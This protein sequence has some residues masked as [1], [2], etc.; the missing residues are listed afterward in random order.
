MEALAG[1][2]ERLAT[3]ARATPGKRRS[4]HR[5]SYTLHD[6][7]GGPAAGPGEPHHPLPIRGSAQAARHDAPGGSSG[8]EEAWG[9]WP[10]QSA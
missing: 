3:S 6:S 2:E 8:T 1:C 10:D 7:A 5:S 9:V 4:F